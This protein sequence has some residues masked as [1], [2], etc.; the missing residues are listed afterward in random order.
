MNTGEDFNYQNANMWFKNM[1]KLKNFLNR[2]QEKYKINVMYSTPSCYLKSLHDS[3]KTWTV[4][5]DDFFPYASNI[6]SFIR[7]PVKNKHVYRVL[8]SQNNKVETQLVPIPEEV[9]RIPGR[10]SAARYEL[11]FY[12]ENIPGLGSKTFK[13]EHVSNTEAKIKE[14][15]VGRTFYLENKHLKIEVNKKGILQRMKTESS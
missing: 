5:T 7:I 10:N 12:A 4:K 13:F 2:N 11:V 9:L 6:S 14:V 1:D 8:N 15:N 3:N